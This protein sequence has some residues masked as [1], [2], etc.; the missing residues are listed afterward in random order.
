[1]ALTDD[2]KVFYELEANGNDSHSVGPYNL[3]SVGSPSFVSGKV[4]NC[5]QLDGSTDYFTLADNADISLGNLDM[6]V[7][8]WVYLDSVGTVSMILSKWGSTGGVDQEYYLR[9]NNGLPGF[10][11]A[12][13]DSALGTGFAEATTFG[14]ASTATWYFV[15]AWHDA[16]NDLLGIAVNGGAANTVAHS[17][18][19]V[20]GTF[21]LELGNGSEVTGVP[22]NGRLD[23]WGL[24]KRVLTS[25]ERTDLY[26]GGS[27]L[28]YAAMSSGGGATATPAQGALSLAGTTGRL[29]FT[30][31]LP[32]EA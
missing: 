23:Q 11:F 1:M 6:T 8:G 16:A 17:T 30:I 24:W 12:V 18:G 29:G 4:G 26:N 13:R 25:Q 20:N 28:S 27:G 15:A 21:R 19:S 3:T 14:A 7:A 9:Y 31:N 10:Q 32:D 22:M 5:A 2:L